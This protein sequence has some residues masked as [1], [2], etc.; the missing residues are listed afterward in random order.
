MSIEFTYPLPSPPKKKDLRHLNRAILP[1]DGNTFSP[2]SRPPP[3]LHAR[4]ATTSTAGDFPNDFNC[5]WNGCTYPVPRPAKELQLVVLV[6]SLCCLSPVR[7]NAEIR[8][9]K[10]VA[11]SASKRACVRARGACKKNLA[12]WGEGRGEGEGIASQGDTRYMP[13]RITH[14]PPTRILSSSKAAAPPIDTPRS[15]RW[16]L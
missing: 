5:T 15:P 3:L 1:I 10:E 6:V 16:T 14:T 7:T 11:R 2:L 8:E 9:G 4:A 12:R 13:E